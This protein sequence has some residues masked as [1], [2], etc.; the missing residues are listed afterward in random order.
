[1]DEDLKRL[2]GIIH[3]IEHYSLSERILDNAT[4]KAIGKD[5]FD[6]AYDIII[7]MRS[8]IRNEIGQ[9]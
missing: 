5:L 9:E 7:N 3:V 4:F 2:E 8:A 6:C 1:M